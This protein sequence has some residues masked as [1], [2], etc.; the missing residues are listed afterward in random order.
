MPLSRETPTSLETK[1]LRRDFTHCPRCGSVTE[2]SKSHSGAPSEFWRECT[3]CNTYINTYVPQAHQAAVHRDP[4]R[5]VGNFGGYG[6]G[7]T[8]TS[9]EE[10]FKHIFLTPKGNTLIGANVASQY[11]ATIKRDIE[12]DIPEEFIADWSAQK[13][14]VNFVNG[15]RVMYRPF[16]DAGKIRSYTLSMWV[17]VEASEIKP[18]AYIQL[19]AR[20]RSLA[21][22]TPLLD[23]NGDIVYHK[24]TEGELVPVI[25]HDWCKGISESNPDPGWIKTDLLDYSDEI[26]KHGKVLD[27]FAILET[28]RDK[29][30]SSHI[31]ASDAN[32]YLPPNFLDSLKKNRPAWWINKFIHGSFLYAEGLI[33]PSAMKY[34]VKAQEPEKRWRRIVAFDYGLAD[35]SVF[36]FGAIDEKENLLVIYKEIVTNNKSVEEL[37]KLFHEGAKDIP[38]GNWVCQPLI[39]PKSAPKRDY[40][41]KTLADHFIDYGLVFKPGHINLDARI[42][43]LNTYLESG[44]IRIYGETCPVLVKEL[45]SYKFASQSDI[46]DGF[47]DKP[48]DKNNHCINC[49][50]WMTMEL[51][52]DPRNLIHG[53]YSGGRKISETY[54]ELDIEEEYRVLTLFDEPDRDNDRVV[55]DYEF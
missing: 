32:Q 45:K 23:E 6:S 24:T 5:I 27:K 41:K 53:A 20:L 26:H 13:Q 14:H 30:I 52:A 54:E 38:P 47:S 48:V 39:D 9:R 8:Y 2:I 12:A 11:E 25:D 46:N 3:R 42:Y 22:T 49:L 35:N 4:H 40:D 37:A 18:E 31:T 33:Y 51:P 19:K 17:A 36:L 34:V 55:V 29:D 28:E 21:A 1:K 16:D 15:H 50:E 7:K 43:R 10:V 44:K